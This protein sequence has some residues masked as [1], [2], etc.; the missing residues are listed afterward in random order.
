MELNWKHVHAISEKVASL[1]EV[2][3]LVGNT[4]SARN[5]Y[6]AA[7]ILEREALNQLPRDGSYRRTIGVTLVS[8]LVL[9]SKA[10]REHEVAELKQEWIQNTHLLPDFAIEE[11]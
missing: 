4:Q 7:A 8:A 6:E 10:G 2:Q 11:I 5:F 9:Y 3:S 1:A